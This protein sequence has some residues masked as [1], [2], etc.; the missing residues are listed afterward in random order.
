MVNEGVNRW[1]VITN[2][3]F[4]GNYFARG[5]FVLY[6]NH[7]GKYIEISFNMKIPFIAE[8]IIFYQKFHIELFRYF[9][10]LH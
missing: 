6:I 8:Y 10:C 3:D 2:L 4:G 5:E 1:L 7:S 9:L